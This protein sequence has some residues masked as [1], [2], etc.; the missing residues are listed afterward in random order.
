MRSM[1]L[2]CTLAFLVV[3]SRLTLLF[4]FI[5]VGSAFN[6]A[7]IQVLFNSIGLCVTT[8]T[9][10]LA[11]TVIERYQIINSNDSSGLSKCM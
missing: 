2:Y 7:S 10:Q 3:L 5:A 6:M 8:L 11:W 9:D 4:S 1:R